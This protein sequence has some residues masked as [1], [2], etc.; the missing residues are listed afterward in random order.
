MRI[1]GCRDALCNARL[2]ADERFVSMMLNI[3]GRAK[4][5]RD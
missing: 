2:F 5:D 1:W 4:K 3:Q